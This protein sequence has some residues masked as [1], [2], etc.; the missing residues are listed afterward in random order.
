MYFAFVDKLGEQVSRSYDNPFDAFYRYN[1]DNDEF[2]IVSDN[3]V[4]YILDTRMISVK[5][6]VSCAKRVLY[7]FEEKYPDD[8]R[9]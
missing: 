7:I 5:W 2:C 9:P 3:K 4:I 1:N 8:K 6:A